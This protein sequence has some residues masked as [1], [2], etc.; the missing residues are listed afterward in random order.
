MEF[1]NPL[2]REVDLDLGAARRSFQGGHRRWMALP[3]AMAALSLLAVVT[4]R[5]RK[6]KK[7]SGR[8]GGKGGKG[9]PKGHKKALL[10]THGGDSSIAGSKDVTA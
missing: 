7:E 9:G 8:L 2:K 10:P 5:M 4:A 1:E 3:W 6:P